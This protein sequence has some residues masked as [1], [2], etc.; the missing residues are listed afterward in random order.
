[1]IEFH[2]FFLL[3]SNLQGHTI[4]HRPMPTIISPMNFF[5]ASPFESEKA[6]TLKNI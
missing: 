2:Q 1:M 4:N 3:K 5:L 6:F